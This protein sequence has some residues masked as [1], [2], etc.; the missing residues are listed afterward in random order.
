M[1]EYAIRDPSG[2]KLSAYFDRA[3]FVTSLGSPSGSIFT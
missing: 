2:E 3:S 1:A